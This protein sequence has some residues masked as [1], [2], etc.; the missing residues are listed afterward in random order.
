ML[1]RIKHIPKQRNSTLETAD[2]L[3][4]SKENDPIIVQSAGVTFT[5]FRYSK[6]K[7][8]EKHVWDFFLPLFHVSPNALQRELSSVP[9]LVRARPPA[10]DR[11]L[12][13]ASSTEI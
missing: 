11:G 12:D 2:G 1:V 4:P 8:K 7:K 5:Q 6:R 3:M 9:T 13:C 10:R